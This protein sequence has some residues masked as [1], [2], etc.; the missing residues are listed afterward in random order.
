MIVEI[1][2]GI[3]LSI[4]IVIAIVLIFKYSVFIFIVVVVIGSLLYVVAVDGLDSVFS[5]LGAIV[6]FSS[7]VVA[8]FMIISSFLKYIDKHLDIKTRKKI[9]IAIFFIISVS[10][11]S[12]LIYAKIKGF[13]EGPILGLLVTLVLVLIGFEIND[14]TKQKKL[15]E[16]EK[17]FKD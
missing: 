10:L 9:G 2:L 13:L 7:S 6:I 16:E 4:I 17:N 1:A 11:L 12:L 3:L 5:G 8:V 15:K 14:R